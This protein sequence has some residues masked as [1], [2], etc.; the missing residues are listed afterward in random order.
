[1]EK[2]RMNLAWKNAKIM[3][4]TRKQQKCRM[5]K[6][7]MGKMQITCKMQKQ[8][9]TRMQKTENVEFQLAELIKDENQKMKKCRIQNAKSRMQNAKFQKFKNNKIQKIRMQN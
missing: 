9:K 6:I 5:H 7:R 8:Q 4:K 1:M 3:H 2:C